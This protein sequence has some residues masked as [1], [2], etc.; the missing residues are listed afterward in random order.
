MRLFLLLALFLAGCAS[1]GLHQVDTQ[2]ALQSATPLGDFHLDGRI[3]A[4]DADRAV[5][6]SVSWD[7]TG[8]VDT[9]LLS[10]PLGQGAAE[11]RR[12]AGRAELVMAD[13]ERVVESSDE[14]L[15]ARILGISL[16]LDGLASWLA[17]RPQ[18]GIAFQGGLDGQGHLAWLEQEGWR[19]EYGSYARHGAY[20][21]P[22]K[23]VA[24][25]GEDVDFRFVADH[26]Q[27][28]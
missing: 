28:K 27:P 3:S 11:I 7:R 23:V 20:W 24:R 15:L 13:G 8:S 22:G 12:E 5:S 14:R 18:P 9:L 16:P 19:I 4:R 17:G 26:W 2:A 1:P 6:G 10:G 21:L 25:H